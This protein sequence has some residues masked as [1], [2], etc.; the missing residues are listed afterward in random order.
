MLVRV[1]NNA[2][3]NL[4]K[5]QARNLIIHKDVSMRRF[6]Y[7][8]LCGSQAALEAAHGPDLRSGNGLSDRERHQLNQ[9]QNNLSRTI[10][11]YKHN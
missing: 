4:I 7:A 2:K 3:A 11:R 10:D 8:A 9:R 1:V 6:T 5:S